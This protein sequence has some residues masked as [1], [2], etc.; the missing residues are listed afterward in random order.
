MTSPGTWPPLLPLTKLSAKPVF[1]LISLIQC[2]ASHSPSLRNSRASTA[3]GSFLGGEAF[4]WAPNNVLTSISHKLG[5]LTFF[6]VY[7][8]SYHIAVLWGMCKINNGRQGPKF[9][10]LFL[11]ILEG[12]KKFGGRRP[13][14]WGLLTNTNNCL[15]E[16]YVNIHICWIE[17]C[18][19]VQTP[20]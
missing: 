19:F 8:I 3:V 15:K 5:I 18:V 6:L 7:N 13:S 9:H 11:P 12:W 10:S 20:Q 14:Y 17:L 2:S 1:I 4:K 16:I